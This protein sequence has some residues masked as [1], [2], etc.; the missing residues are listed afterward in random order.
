M[1]YSEHLRANGAT[2]DEVKL[3]DVPAARKAFDA[4]SA[5]AEAR[6]LDY[7]KK[8]D[9]WYTDTIKPAYDK[10]QADATKAIADAA[11]LRSLVASS[12]DDG[13]RKVAEEMG[14]KLDG[15]AAPKVAPTTENLLDTSKFVT[16]DALKQMTDNVGAGLAALQDMV[17]EHMQLFPDKRLDVRSLRT[18][19]VA[20]GKQVYDYWQ[21]KYGVLA[22]RE[23]ADKL[24]RET[25]EA[26]LRKEGR[27]A[28]I[29][30]FANN[31]A[32]PNMVPG[33]TSTNVLAPRASAG[34]EKQPWE[35]GLDG[36][37]G[38]NDRVGRGTKLFIQKQAGI[39]S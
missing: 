18:E 22:A 32:N 34:R 28:A 11:R 5:D 1:T 21:T 3:L 14:Y 15:T 39:V 24:A 33:S 37:N 38:S 6:V 2:E 7:K 8:A 16:V 26:K 12:Q 13:L 23:A 10:S 35:S 19:A 17:A 20:A 30:E 4:I 27:D 9:D 31:N 36:E 29:A 25:H